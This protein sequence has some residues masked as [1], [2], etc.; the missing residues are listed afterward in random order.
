[1]GTGFRTGGR[2]TASVAAVLCLGASLFSQQREG[3]LTDPGSD[4]AILNLENKTRA[5]RLSEQ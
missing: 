5:N 3:N 4:A 2:V 1:M